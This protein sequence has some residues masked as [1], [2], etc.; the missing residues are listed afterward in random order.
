MF[1]LQLDQKEAYQ[2]LNIG[3]ISGQ[4]A[5]NQDL[6]PWV[7]G[8]L[9]QLIEDAPMRGSLLKINGDCSLQLA[10]VIARKVRHLYS[11]IAVFD[12]DLTKYV[13]VDSHSPNYCLGQLID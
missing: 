13:V 11:A 1:K 8:Y 5:S 2:Q 6:V 9:S 10:F 12:S 7:D 3:F 4:N